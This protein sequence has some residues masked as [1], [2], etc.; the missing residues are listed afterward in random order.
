[1][2]S[3]D[4]VSAKDLH[5]KQKKPAAPVGGLDPN[6]AVNF[7]M[8]TSGLYPGLCDH[9]V[10]LAYGQAH[11]G[12]ESAKAHWA[13]TPANL[14]HANDT[15]P[16]V[17]ALVFFSGGDYGHVA[18]VTGKAPNGEP[19]ITTTHTQGGKPVEMPLSKAAGLGYSGWATPYFGGKTAKLDGATLTRAVSVV[20][21][22]DPAT[23]DYRGAPPAGQ[24]K[25]SLSD[26]ADVVGFDMDFVK[27]H[28]EILD[29]FTKATNENWFTSG[30]IGKAKFDAAIQRT[31]WA[32]QN[33]PFA[34]E[35]L[36]AAAKNGGKDKAFL[37]QNRVAEEFVREAAQR[38]GAKLDDRQLKFFAKQTLMNGWNKDAT[39]AHFL[40]QALTGQLEFFNPKTGRKD[41]FQTDH[42]NYE[43]GAINKTIQA[44][45]DSAYKNGVTYNDDWYRQQA[46]SV[47]G[48]MS[49]LDDHLTEIRKQGS[50]LFPVYADKVAAGADVMDIASPFINKMASVLEIDPNSISLNDPTI[51]KALGGVDSKGNPVA[52]GLWDFEKSLRQDSRWQYTKQAND[53][54][55]NLTSKIISMFG[56]GG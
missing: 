51:K 48:G 42:L 16:P 7:A 14:K 9:F 23:A 18:I 45:K 53:E 1:M 4:P 34:Q 6:A 32:Q 52:V 31:G 36:L 43:S 17:G 46:R 11:S 47:A 39:R 38:V 3:T 49:T 30:D 37:E 33:G 44:L 24:D 21:S 40:D 15:R 19:I 54:I 8:D 26:A 2:Q 41:L 20:G 56:M 5:P 50:S 22:E 25:L 29:V 10:G 13:Q 27:A 55:S 35:Y 28:K 12:Y